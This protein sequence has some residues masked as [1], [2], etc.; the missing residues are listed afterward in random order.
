MREGEDCLTFD[1]R[2]SGKRLKRKVR[3][4]LE[5]DDY[6]ISM[7]HHGKILVR[8]FSR[9]VEPLMNFDVVLYICYYLID[10]ASSQRT[11]RSRQ[12]RP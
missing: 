3:L 6:E 12:L 11:N 4:R 10:Q 9:E 7:T 1:P 8:W 5:A 2:D